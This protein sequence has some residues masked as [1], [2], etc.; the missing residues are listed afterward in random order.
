MN[1]KS[2]PTY[3]SYNN[4]LSVS[5][6]KTSELV[7]PPNTTCLYGFLKALTGSIFAQVVFSIKS[8]ILHVKNQK[9]EL[10]TPLV[11]AI[12]TFE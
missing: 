12:L 4:N 11:N 3:C 5:I 6:S 9:Q 1:S 7:L 8:K 2:L 10:I